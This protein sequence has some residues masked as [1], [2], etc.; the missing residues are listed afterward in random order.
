[1]G[2]K[3][4]NHLVAAATLGSLLVPERLSSHARIDSLWKRR[5]VSIVKQ[6]ATEELCRK[7]RWQRVRVAAEADHDSTLPRAIARAAVRNLACCA[8]Q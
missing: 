2:N 4:R 8:P 7:S 5:R 3:Y 6:R 1:M